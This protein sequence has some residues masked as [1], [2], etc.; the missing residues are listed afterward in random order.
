MLRV[1]DGTDQEIKV[2]DR[3]R[4]YFD[5]SHEGILVD[6]NNKSFHV[7]WDDITNVTDYPIEALAGLRPA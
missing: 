2:N 7:K 3:V 5:E 4:W 6:L 1:Y